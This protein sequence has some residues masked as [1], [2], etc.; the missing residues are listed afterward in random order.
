MHGFLHYFLSTLDPMSNIGVARALPEAL[1]AA[2]WLFL[3]A[4]VFLERAVFGLDRGGIPRIGQ[5]LIQSLLAG[6]EPAGIPKQY[7]QD[8]RDRVIVAVERGN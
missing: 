3:V 2:P 8:L 5:I 4:A 6:R 1:S 7:S